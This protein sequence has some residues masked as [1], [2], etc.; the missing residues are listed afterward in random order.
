MSGSD[1][2]PALRPTDPHPGHP[3]DAMPRGRELVLILVGI[4]LALF[5]AALDQTVIVTALPT[6]AADLGDG[7]YLSWVVTAYLL[8]ATA[9][10]PLYGKL[11]DIKGRRFALY[12]ALFV[13]TIGSVM[14]ALAPSMLV[15][16][17]ARGVQGLGAGGLMVLP[18]T[19]IADVI[20]AR[21]R[22]KYQGYIATVFTLSS[23]AGPVIGGTL[24]DFFHWSLI[25][26]INL[27][28]AALSVAVG[29]PALRRLP[30]HEWPH[31]LDLIGATLM[32]AA[33]V[34]ALLPLT[35]AGNA[36]GWLATPTLVLIVAAA[37][38]WALFL[39]RL[40]LAAEPLI[41]LQILRN[42]VVATGVLAAFFSMGT[43]IGLTVVVPLLFETLRG[44]SASQSGFAV[45]PFMI[46]TVIGAT[47][48]GQAMYRLERYKR[49]CVIGL[50]W[51]AAATTV[52]AA[53]FEHLSNVSLAICFGLVSLGIG[54]TLPITTV[55]VQ[56]AVQPHQTGTVT[57]VISF[58]RQFGGAVLAALFGAIL[59]MDAGTPGGGLEDLGAHIGDA[60]GLGQ[61]F[62]WILIAAVANLLIAFVLMILH[63]ERPLR[64]RPDPGPAGDV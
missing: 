21:E 27:P 28:F 24:A 14:C 5:V 61:G 39:V 49:V 15:L 32:I 42:P 54:T 3:T 47:V 48:G 35:W 63:E 62:R 56:N 44:Y 43:F 7:G 53:G 51:A 22:G 26:W 58:F 9:T 45:I 1:P 31:R 25:F 38:L 57:A 16:V 23:L 52:L 4:M 18:M 2:S 11:A 19:V 29:W 13:F 17:I 20:P 6:I 50:G 60:P 59:L 12:L 55:S 40:R 46:G 8:T 34:A 64:G 10:A 30:R 41:P 33:T 37:A 36:F